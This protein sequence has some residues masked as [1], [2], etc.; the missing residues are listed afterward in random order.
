[1]K[2]WTKKKTR[3]KLNVDIQS[4][5]ELPYPKVRVEWIDCVSDSGWANEKEFEK[6]LNSGDEIS[7]QLISFL[8]FMADNFFH[9]LSLWT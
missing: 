9:L 5:N 4:A 1:M 2:D 7:K 3:R 6:M 8:D